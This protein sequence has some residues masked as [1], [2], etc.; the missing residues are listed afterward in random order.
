MK[1]CKKCNK[2]T[3]NANKEECKISCALCSEVYHYNCVDISEEQMKVISSVKNLCWSCDDCL[4]ENNFQKQVLK[5]LNEIEC[6]VKNH[7]KMLKDHQNELDIVKKTLGSVTVEDLSYTPTSASIS[8]PAV[9][10]RSSKNKR[11]YAQMLQSSSDNATPE[12]GKTPNA[13]KKPKIDNKTKKDPVLV[14]RLKET[15]DKIA[16]PMNTD[17]GSN[18]NEKNKV[19]VKDTIKRLLNPLIDPV[20]SIRTT[21]RGN[22]V[23]LCNDEKAVLE[24][25]KKLTEECNDEFDIN[26][27]KSVQPI[28]NVTGFDNE[29][30]SPDS[31]ISAAVTQNDDIFNTESTL[32]VL[33]VKVNKSG[34]R[35]AKIETDLK[36]FQRVM[37]NKRLRIGWNSCRVYEYVNV[38][39]CYKCN[40]YGHIAGECKSAVDVCAKCAG[41]HKIENCTSDLSQCVNCLKTNKDLKL[42]V[43]V[44]HTAFSIKCPVLQRKM[45]S[46]KERMRYKD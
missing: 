31:L 10:S 41:E 22:V 21:S 37:S 33:Q 14:I 29:Y 23:V 27:P 13:N 25:K 24:M 6:L 42:S 2:T 18:D 15:T 1:N 28:F 43:D 20:K 46:K 19:N 5:K 12:A 45:Q 44:N 40:D 9:N 32:N 26:E 3:R 11:T 34:V 38:I 36:T 35:T 17:D 16:V 8:K 7:E 39:R 30:S 4:K